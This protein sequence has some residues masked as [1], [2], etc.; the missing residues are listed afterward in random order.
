MRVPS[1]GCAR[2]GRAVMHST[3]PAPP[4]G[5]PSLK[6]LII[7]MRVVREKGLG[8]LRRHATPALDSVCELLGGAAFDEATRPAAVEALVRQ[9]TEKVGGGR[10]G[11]AARYTLGLVAGTRLWSAPER[12]RRA[13]AAQGV[14]VE[15]F[16]KGY[17]GALLEQVAEGVLA[18]LY[19]RRHE[20][21]HNDRMAEPWRSS[22]R[23]ILLSLWPLGYLLDD[24]AE[25]PPRHG[26]GAPL[27]GIQAAGHNQ[28]AQLSRPWNSAWSRVD[29]GSR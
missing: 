3:R 29:D 19:D 28:W 13:A 15:R 21:D 17:E 6:E 26:A 12:R 7:D 10:E 16:R 18:L 9:A 5:S 24:L 23:G 14:S 2:H 27:W 8:N 20:N 1:T 4:N 25:E 22:P 11:D